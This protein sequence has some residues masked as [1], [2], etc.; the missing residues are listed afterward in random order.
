MTRVVRYPDEPLADSIKRRNQMASRVAGRLGRWSHIWARRV[1][2]W[3]DHLN[4]LRNAESLV[5]RIYHWHGAAWLRAQR[6]EHG[7]AA[8][9][10]RTR[11]RVPISMAVQPRWEESV[12]AA[13]ILCPDAADSQ[14][15]LA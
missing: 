9:A 15:I 4:R 3:N 12:K 14:R 10:G 11:T 13:E 2:S 5:S 7:S 8:S 6:L 1:I